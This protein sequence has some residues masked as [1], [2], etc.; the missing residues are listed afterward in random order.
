VYV[1]F[2]TIDITS[3]LG[4]FKIY[5][6]DRWILNMGTLNPVLPLQAEYGAE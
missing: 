2:N 1:T 6:N 4:K 3:V 5:V